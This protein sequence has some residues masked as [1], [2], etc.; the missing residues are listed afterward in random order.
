MT[1]DRPLL[2]VFSGLPGTGK[3]TLS[4]ALARRLGALHLRIDVIVQAMQ[5]AGISEVG[6]AGY[7]VANAIA[8]TNLRL[9]RTVI[10]DCVNPVRESREEWSLVAARSSV[11]IA[12][13]QLICSGI[14]EHRRRVEE[15][16]ADI[17][18]HVLPNWD[19][20]MR[21]E[22]E[23]RTDN[24]LALDTAAVSPAALVQQCVAYV[25]GELDGP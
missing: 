10:A 18:G 2:V 15:R 21:H 22:F 13:I 11:R 6:A 8:E 24:H 7:A 1:R 3:T 9:G 20:V 4:T 5:A 19:A 14:A 12:D 23:Q 25:S 16:T 17:A